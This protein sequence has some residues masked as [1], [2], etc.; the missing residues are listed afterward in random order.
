MTSRWTSSR[1]TFSRSAAQMASF[2]RFC[3]HSRPTRPISRLS[4]GQAQFGEELSAGGVGRAGRGPRRWESRGSAPPAVRARRRNRARRRCWPRR[5]RNAG[6]HSD[7]RPARPSPSR[8]RRSAGRR[9]RVGR[10]TPGPP[11]SRRHWP[12]RARYGPAR[13]AAAATWR[14]QPPEGK[15]SARHRLP[16]TVTGTPAR[17]QVGLAGSAAAER[18]DVDVELLPRQPGGQQGQLLFGPARS[19]EG[20]MWR[21]LASCA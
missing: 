12:Q 14:T 3:G 20:M 15:G 10:R 6:R 13:A 18:A 2:T 9:S 5:N 11:R 4:L 7:R 1:I 21:I 17:P 8:D 19:S 16:I